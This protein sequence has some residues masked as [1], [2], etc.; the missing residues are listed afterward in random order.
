MCLEQGEGRSFAFQISFKPLYVSWGEKRLIFFF[1]FFGGEKKKK[2]KKNPFYFPIKKEW[3]TQKKW[4][5]TLLR[6]LKWFPHMFANN[7]SHWGKKKKR[8]KKKGTAIKYG[9]RWFEHF[10][11]I[12]PPILGYQTGNLFIL[13]LNEWLCIQN[14]DC[15]FKIF[16]RGNSYFLLHSI[17]IQFCRAKAPRSNETTERYPMEINDATVLIIKNQH[18]K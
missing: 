17:Y 13:A 5:N 6:P 14:G 1:F 2:T 18:L 4:Q 8:K 16:R 11:H 9:R 12:I 7:A 10:W 15:S 3:Q